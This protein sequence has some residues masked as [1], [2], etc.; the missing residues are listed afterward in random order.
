MRYQ[1]SSGQ[2]P[3][4]CELGVAKLADY[5]C[6][7]YGAHVLS[8]SPGYHKGTYRSV[9]I[10]CEQDL[11]EYVGSVQWIC[12]SPYRP[13][14]K[15]KNWF[16]DFSCCNTAEIADFQE[17]LVAFETFRS[18]GKGGQNVNKVETGVRAIYLPTG[19]A[20]VCTEERSQYANKQKALARLRE[21]IQLD[22]C[23]RKAAAQNNNWSFHNQLERG[24]AGVV[25]R[26]ERFAKE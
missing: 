22:N 25:F 20:V 21:Q 17:G 4:E 14:H 23:H 18:G 1:I 5:L 26:G 3:A 11:S 12:R 10:S 19:Q 15:R 24:N 2:G 8:T 9:Q 7:Q 13:A 16:I 6:R